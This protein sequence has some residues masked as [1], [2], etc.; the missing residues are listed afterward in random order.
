MQQRLAGGDISLDAPLDSESES[1]RMDFV[2]TNQPDASDRLAEV[3]FQ[4]LLKAKFQEFRKT[5][6]DRDREIFDRRLLTDEPVT[7]REIGE[8][9]G[10]SRE[11]V[12]QLEA[13]LKARLRAFLKGVEGI[14]D[15]AS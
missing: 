6:S 11:R 5:L 3:E 2:A 15:G 8:G 13:D 9:F 14:G 4:G 7:L 12:R 1:S 10:V